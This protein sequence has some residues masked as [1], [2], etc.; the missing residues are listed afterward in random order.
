MR[1]R[2][3]APCTRALARAATGPAAAPAARNLAPGGGRPTVPLTRCIM[4]RFSALIAAAGLLFL[5]ACGSMSSSAA[6]APVDTGAATESVDT[7]R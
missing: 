2:W 5:S 4:T 1:K 7:G 6:Q 3:H